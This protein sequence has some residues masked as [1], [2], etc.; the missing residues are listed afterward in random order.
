MTNAKKMLTHQGLSLF[1]RA[2]T[3]INIKKDFISIRNFH[4]HFH[5]YSF[6]GSFYKSSF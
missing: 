1:I 6:G 3:D 4:F 5:D 2:N